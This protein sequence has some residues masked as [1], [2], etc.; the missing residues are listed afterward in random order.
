MHSCSASCHAQGVFSYFL[1]F[2]GVPNFLNVIILFSFL[3]FLVALYV[4]SA[5]Y[6]YPTPH[7]PSSQG[8]S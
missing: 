5:F 6:F 3:R 8:D 7:H 4:N 1:S 2:L